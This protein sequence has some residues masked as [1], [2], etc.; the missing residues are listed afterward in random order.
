MYLV[1]FDQLKSYMEYLEV[2]PSEQVMVLVAGKSAQYVQDL[3]DYMNSKNI[4]FFGGIYAALLVESKTQYE[5]FLVQKYEPIYSSLVLPY[6]MRFKIEEDCLKDSTAIVLVDGLS[7][8][9]KDLT[10][11]IY[12]KVGNK[13][14]YIGGGAGFYDLKQRPCIFDNKG[15]YQD[16]LYI[17]IIKEKMELAVKHG[18]NKLMGPF[19]VTKSE[20]NVLSEIDNEN[21]LAVYR[22][23]IEEVEGLRLG[24]EDFFTYARDYPFGIVEKNQ[25]EMV[26][27]DPITINDQDEIICVAG[28]PQGSNLYLLKG[29]VDTLLESSV[30][31]ATYCAQKAP[32]R[33]VPLLFDCISRAMFMEDI[34]DMELANIQKRLKYKVEG[35]LSIG[36]VSSTNNGELTI[37]NKSTILGLLNTDEI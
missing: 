14:K 19:H 7:S 37:H 10:D 32:Q 23:M 29:N 15:I 4:R 26:V 13:V 16:V 6:M 30:E 21:A 36:E 22:D 27:R 3:Q 18:W 9:M 31:I 12:N 25:T 24:R 35:A 1:N 17:C 5:G 34:F 28:I 33:Y 8:K 2:K 20:A 11:T